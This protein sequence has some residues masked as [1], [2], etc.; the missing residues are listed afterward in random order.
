MTQYWCVNFDSEECLKHGIKHDLWMMQYQYEDGL[1]NVFQGGNQKSA[2][3]T[4]WNRL[5]EIK[6]GDWFVAYLPKKRTTTGNT[7]FAVGRVCTPRKPAKSGSHVST[8]AEYVSAQRS[9]EFKSG[10]I[11]YADAP[12]FY[13]DFDDK[14]RSDDPLMRYA[15]RIDV[16][17]WQDYVISGIPW[18][19][20][21]GIPPYEI[22]R[23]FFKINKKSFDKIAK[24]L[25]ASSKGAPKRQKRRD[26]SSEVV[27][28]SVVEALERSQAKSQGFMLDSKLRA[29]LEKY[30]M[31]AATQHFKS[32]GYTV[33]DH[34][35]NHPYDLRCVRS[36]EVLY[37]EVKGTQTDGKGV[38][39]TSGEVKFAQRYSKH[40]VL[41]VLHS[42]QVSKDRKRLSKGVQFV[43]HP[44]VIEQAALNP[45]SY[46]YEVPSA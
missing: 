33:E 30:S 35:K 21:L 36:D 26:K 13:E 17:D 8:V 1:G 38:I 45:L 25:T 46:K 9:H 18:L 15:Q 6:A 31:D 10:V 11:H 14:W 40:M 20:D 5:T 19:T 28:E 23:A 29:A 22:Q 16:E 39:L 34:S 3:T 41:F 32:L 37:V 44:W 12:V 42:I 27:D 4:N 2:T 43:I 24:Q 7:F